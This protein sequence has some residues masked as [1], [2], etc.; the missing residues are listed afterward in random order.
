MEEKSYGLNSC[1]DSYEAGSPMIIDKHYPKI[2]SATLNCIQ[3][4][5]YA[6][7]LCLETAPYV[8]LF[9]SL[10]LYMNISICLL[11][12]SINILE[13]FFFLMTIFWKPVEINYNCKSVEITN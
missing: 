8:R 1:W 13:A 7:S 3:N 5:L 10:Y 9:T 6:L 4:M 2:G 11:L 12:I